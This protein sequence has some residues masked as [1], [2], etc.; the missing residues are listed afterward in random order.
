ME[1]PSDVLAPA[2]QAVAQTATDDEW[3]LYS[4]QLAPLR[5]EQLHEWV[6]LLLA[7]VRGA[8]LTDGSLVPRSH[9]WWVEEATYHGRVH[10]YHY[11]TPTLREVGGHIGY[12]VAPTSRG[13]GHGSAMLA[14]ARPIAAA[15]GIDCLLVTCDPGNVGSRRIIE[16]NGGLLQDERHGKLRYWLPTG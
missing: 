9:F 4:T 15:L 6:Q 3:D 16:N 7:D 12:Y 13:H 2:V 11:L 14:A 5:P 10:L 8:H 1:S